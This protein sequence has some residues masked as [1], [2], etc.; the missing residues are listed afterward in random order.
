M[1]IEKETEKAFL[2]NK[3]GIS[4][5]IRLNWL[6]GNSVSGWDLTPAGWKAYHIAAREKA[7]HLYFD[8]L[9][10]F[11]FVR[12]TEKAVLLRCVVMQPDGTKTNTE[13]WLP[14]SMTGNWKFVQTKI[15]EIEGG[16]P[17]KGTYVVWS[18]AEG[19]ESKG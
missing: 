17:F 1:Y 16:F 18:G 5:W 8:A 13:F 3:D 9:K 11:E 10:E 19:R 15:K 14:K 2:I 4:F 6:R 7:K 12:D